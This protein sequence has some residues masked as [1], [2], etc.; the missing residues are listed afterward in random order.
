MPID[1]YIFR[2]QGIDPN[3]LAVFF[4][5]LSDTELEELEKMD[6]TRAN[7]FVAER[8]SLREILAQRLLATPQSL[9]FGRS[10]LGKPEL[11]KN[12]DTRFN[13]SHCSDLFVLAVSAGLEV[14]VD[15]ER[16]QRSNNLERI[17]L[18]YFSDNEIEFLMANPAEINLRFARLWTIKE[19][20]GKLR[21]TGINKTFLKNATKV[22]QGIIS[23]NL[24]WLED[25]IVCSSYEKDSHLLS[26]A[27]TGED[28]PNAN[29]NESGW[30]KI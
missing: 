17:A 9:E 18:H 22:T 8:G 3:R 10:A 15:I 29:I 24:E 13:L 14:G 21:G 19:S 23:P 5:Y 25:E 1:I 16:T 7:R 12:L 28:T 11:A 27:C 30:T 6:S 2:Y 26:I 4:G 20:I